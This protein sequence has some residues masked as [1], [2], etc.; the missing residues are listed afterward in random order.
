MKKVSLI[1]LAVLVVGIML[2]SGC[3][4]PEVEGTVINIQKNLYDEA[5]VSAQKAVEKYP[6]NAEAWFYWGWLY[7][8]QKKDYEKMNEGFDKALKLNPQQKVTIAGRSMTV[9]E[10]VEMYRTGKFADN[11]NSAVKMISQA[12]QM[13]DQEK[14]K[15]LFTAAQKKLLLATQIDPTRGEPYHPLALT[16]LVLGDT[17]AALE[18]V[19]KGLEK[20]PTNETLLIGSG[21]I[22]LLTKNYDKASESFKKALEVNPNN[23]L[24]YQK[25]GNLEAERGDWEKAN[26]YYQ[27]AI[28]MEPDNTDLLYNIGVGY[29]KQEK[30]DE[31]IPYFQKAVE[32]D[33][34]DLLTTRILG[35]CYVQAEKNDEG[36]AFLED[37]VQRFPDEASLWEYLAILYGRKGMTEKADE[38]F[39]KSK[40]LK[41]EEGK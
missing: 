21:E 34:N 31:A 1:L 40:E 24:V 12:Q 16:Y 7:G 9:K 2:I 27:K 26:T 11:Y 41:G 25:L 8:D 28:E 14:Q 29:Y 18:T 17:T 10:A 32:A 6:E 15:K 33:P 30:Y 38:A 35:I 22:Y 37:A 20:N 5:L 23:A 13:D 4:P 36:I 19:Q 39:K 3:R